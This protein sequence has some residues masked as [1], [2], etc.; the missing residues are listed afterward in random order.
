MYMIR[1]VIMLVP[2]LIVM[3]MVAFFLIQLPPGDWVSFRIEQLRMSGVTVSD[4]EAANLKME[5]GLDKP[6]VVRYINWVRG[7]V[8]KGY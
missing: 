1:R 8:L 3:S 2:I 5:F 4:I 7:I 6:P